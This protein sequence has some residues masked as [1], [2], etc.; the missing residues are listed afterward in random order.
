MTQTIRA[1]PEMWPALDDPS[2]ADQR[3]FIDH[4]GALARLR[5]QFPD[6]L[7]ALDAVAQVTGGP[8]FLAIAG[9][10]RGNELPADW[11]AVVDVFRVRGVRHGPNGESARMRV[12]CPAPL[13]DAMAEAITRTAVEMADLCFPYRLRKRPAARG[14]G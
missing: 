5:P 11:M 1:H 13:D 7:E 3:W 14:F 4:P 2:T 6:E 9:C 10:D 8:G 12:A